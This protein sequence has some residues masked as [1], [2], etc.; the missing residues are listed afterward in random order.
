MNYDA[1]NKKKFRC[2]HIL[3]P[4]NDVA[5]P[6]I[7]DV[8]GDGKLELSYIVG[9]ETI[10]GSQ[11][12]L[13][14]TTILKLRLRTF[15]IEDRFMEVFGKGKLDF[16]R[17]LPPDDQ[18]WAKYMGKTGDSVYHPKHQLRKSWRNYY[19]ITGVHV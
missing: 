4:T 2:A 16:S 19:F 9:W 13:G 14:G 11:E 5:T 8:N 10:P 18:P 15:T 17:F 3:V 6:T 7:G 1:N 12:Y